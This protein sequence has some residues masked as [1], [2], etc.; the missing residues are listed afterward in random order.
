M[1]QK[2]AFL[3]DP[4][5]STN[6][7]TVVQPWGDMPTLMRHASRARAAGDLE[8]AGRFYRRAVELDPNSAQAWAGCAA[9]T[10]SIDEAIV[11]WGYSLALEP[12][13][14]TRSVLSACVME[15][16]KE[17]RVQDGASLLAVGRQLAEAGQWVLAH[18][19]FQ[20]AT[21]LEPSNENAWIWRAGVAS[22]ADEAV[23]CLKRVLELNPQNA[24]AKAGLTWVAARQTAPP[25]S[26]DALQEAALAFEEG[27]RALREGDRA[28]AYERFHQ[29]TEL[30][31]QNASAWFWRGSTAPNV[32]EALDG[33]Q[34]VLA[35][36]PQNQAAKDSEW[37]LR[38]QRLR[39]R[40]TALTNPSPVWLTPIPSVEQ[41]PQ[42]RRRA[43]AIVAFL[44]FGCLAGA[45][46][47]LLWAIW[48]AGY[49]G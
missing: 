44:L 42:R 23:L 26:A 39:E 5:S 25:V 9:T 14:E 15:K 31:P 40:S 49:L 48:Y 2:P 30:D 16:I 17:S 18:H 20:R 36:D 37:W 45:L 13:D 29:A 32:G 41:H 3:T 33:M 8:R 27:Q 11:D 12:N 21:E 10:S 46:L 4:P 22:T 38:V 34:Q 47:V 6:A 43:A 35:I 1:T 24:Q 7:P 28:R 19:L